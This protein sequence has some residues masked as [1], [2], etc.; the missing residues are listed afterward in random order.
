ML[1][2]TIDEV[3]DGD[4]TRR[5]RLVAMRIESVSAPYSICEVDVCAIEDDGGLAVTSCVV[6]IRG[7][8]DIWSVVES[9][10]RAIAAAERDCG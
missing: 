1:A 6:E 5:R 3:P 7:R 8:G 10:C 9:A 4:E 2:V